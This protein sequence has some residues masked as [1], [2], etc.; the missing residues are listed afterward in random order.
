MMLCQSLAYGNPPKA[1]LSVFDDT[2]RPANAR[3]PAAFE[4]SVAVQEDFKIFEDSHKP[5]NHNASRAAEQDR[6]A[7]TS[8]SPRKTSREDLERK[9][10]A[11]FEK[12][13]SAHSSKDVGVHGAS[14]TEASKTLRE[15]V[16]DTKAVSI[17]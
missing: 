5:S 10:S 11:R 13:A 1:P 12:H 3:A 2:A 4:H 9:M 7:P 14:T 8:D 17:A 6:A 15:E 16:V